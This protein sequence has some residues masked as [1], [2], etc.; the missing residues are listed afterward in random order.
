[1]GELGWK[2]FRTSLVHPRK[3]E[4]GRRRFAAILG[5]HGASIQ[6]YGDSEG[7]LDDTRADV[8]S[9]WDLHDVSHVDQGN[10]PREG[11]DLTDWLVQF[12]LT[13]TVIG[14]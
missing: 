1:M 12:K 11:D 3:V 7:D 10:S 9:D 6:A 8:Y 2:G 4:L 14:I 13:G 5:S